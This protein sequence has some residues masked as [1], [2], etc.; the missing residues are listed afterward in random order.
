MANDTQVP[1]ELLRIA[2]GSGAVRVH[3]VAGLGAVSVDGAS[4]VVEG[5]AATVSNGI[6]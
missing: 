4:V 1:L 6:D 3:A 5:A 2:G